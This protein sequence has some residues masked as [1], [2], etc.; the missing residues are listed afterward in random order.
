MSEKPTYEESE[1]KVKELN[2]IE[3]EREQIV[4]SLRES[5]EKYSKLFHSSND[6]IFI[7]D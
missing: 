4:R 5:E 3:A 2:K 1:L 6:A 7:H